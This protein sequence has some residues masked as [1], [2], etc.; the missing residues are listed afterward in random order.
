M[1]KTIT[2]ISKFS[3]DKFPTIEGRDGYSPHRLDDTFIAISP[4]GKKI[5]LLDTAFYDTAGV[6]E[7]GMPREPPMER[8][9]LQVWHMP[10]G[11][12]D[13]AAINI[14]PFAPALVSARFNSGLRFYSEDCL[15]TGS[16]N[17][18]DG[19]GNHLTQPEHSYEPTPELPCELEFYLDTEYACHSFRSSPEGG[20]TREDVC[21]E[22]PEEVNQLEIVS[23]VTLSN[24]RFYVVPD[25]LSGIYFIDAKT[26]TVLDKLSQYDS[27][28]RS[29]CVGLNDELLISGHMDGALCAWNLR[30]GE[31]L[32]TIHGH[33]NEICAV[34]VDS[35]GKRIV[36]TE[37]SGAMIKIW[38][39]KDLIQ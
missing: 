16:G 25:D 9:F 37:R 28:A 35:I 12:G 11:D 15:R 32:C 31:L 22:L 10:D 5:A 19:K 21:R 34:S 20:D 27:Y 39:L 1:P 2:P 6:D 17:W 8:C 23:A 18:Y 7:Y 26:G 13:D 33:D 14:T 29:L 4:A 36:S 30:S 3:A 24:K 38:N